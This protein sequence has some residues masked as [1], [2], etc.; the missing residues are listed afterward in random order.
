M[1]A[2]YLSR[3]SHSTSSPAAASIFLLSAFVLCIS[4][5]TAAVRL[6]A[7]VTVP[8]VFVFGD[9]IVDPG[10]N[11]ELQTI[12]KCNFPPYGRD[13]PGG[14]PTGRFSNG[15]VPSDMLAEL[16]GVKELLPA[17]LD[18]NLQI[19]DL[20]TGVSFAS[21]AAG[22]DP[23]TS[24][25]AELYGLGARRIGITGIPPIGCVPAQRTLRGGIERNCFDDG[26]DAAI[27]FNSKLSSQIDSLS[28]QLSNSKIV[29]IDIY[30][31]FLPLIQNPTKYGFEVSTKGCCGTGN[32]EVSFLCN[33]LDDL[34]TC[35]NDE[36]YVFWDS[37]HPTEKAYK[38]GAGACEFPQELTLVGEF[39]VFLNDLSAKTIF[40]GPGVGDLN[41]GGCALRGRVKVGFHNATGDRGST[42]EGP[43]LLNSRR[44]FGALNVENDMICVPKSSSSLEEVLVDVSG[45]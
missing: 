34:M 31:S 2:P 32:I 22:Y 40:L 13:F 16:V 45:G 30:Y 17:Y 44:E 6:P 33:K 20:L 42:K 24:E 8:A 41:Q 26:N 18:P 37:F 23:Q 5:A 38:L 11:N 15:R 10:N 36:K 14:K 39:L 21:G 1:V 28:S 27:L 12:A 9:S 25:T 19:Q 35:I 3:P 7:N 4:V 43:I 29:Y